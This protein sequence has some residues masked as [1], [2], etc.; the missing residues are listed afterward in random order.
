MNRV[1]LSLLT[2]SLVSCSVGPGTG[3][4]APAAASGSRDAARSRDADRETPR[5][6][7]VD[8]LPKETRL[9][10]IRQLTFGGENAEAYFSGDG[11]RLIFQS[12]RAPFECDQIFTM[13]TDGSDVRRVS[14]GKG[15][16]TC[17]YYHPDGS[18]IVYAST[19]LASADCP[20]PPPHGPTYV[21]AVYESFDIFSARRDGSDLRRLTD[22]P[23][24]DAEATFSADG[25]KIVFTS[26]RDGDLEIYS[27]NADGSEQRR[28]T[29]EPGYDGGPFFSPDGTRICFRASRPAAGGEREKYESLLNR[30][31]VEPSRLEIFVMDADGKNIR[32]VTRSGAAS[33]CPF[34]HPSGEKIIYASN[35]GDPRGRNFDLYL[36][37]IESGEEEQV[38]FEPT[39]DGFPMLSPD[40][41]QLVW[42]SN[43]RAKQRGE[44]NVF[45]ADWVEH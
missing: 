5:A 44:T 7:G 29:F 19:H 18:R 38:T 35:K 40:G 6:T 20:D 36:V 8:L 25:S 4:R 39:F 9:R 31:V 11:R 33:F 43:R 32:Q 41:R 27:M 12:T 17:A 24:Y 23:G 45:I 13:R 26:A 30:A 22:A 37:D 3:G 15:R 10:N 1:C 16:T 34:F 28:L 42:A 21:W 2:F 14:T